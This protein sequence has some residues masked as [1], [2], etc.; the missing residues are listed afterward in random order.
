MQQ[1]R[2]G[3]SMIYAHNPQ[4]HVHT[5]ARYRGCRRMQR[6]SGQVR[7]GGR[8]PAGHLP[9]GLVVQAGGRVQVDLLVVLHG[10]VVATT[11]GQVGHLQEHKMELRQVGKTQSCT[12]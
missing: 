12:Q 11:L 4:V 5:P 3:I 6:G 9:L 7:S 1:Q 2:I 10:Q 8:S